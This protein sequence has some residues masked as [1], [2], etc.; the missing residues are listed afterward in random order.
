MVEDSAGEDPPNNRIWTSGRRLM[1][2]KGGQEASGMEGMRDAMGQDK[3]ST[4]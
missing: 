4:K 1:M 3:A 2:A